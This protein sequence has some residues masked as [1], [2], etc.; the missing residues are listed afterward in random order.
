M[1]NNSPEYFMLFLF[2]STGHFAFF[3]ASKS[4][5]EEIARLESETM[6]A[7]DRACLEIWHH[8]KGWLAS[9]EYSPFLTV[10][11]SSDLVILTSIQT[12]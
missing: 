11:V 7:V 2:L 9:G 3:S 1:E 4:S 5:R 10:S 8:A 12:L 6:E